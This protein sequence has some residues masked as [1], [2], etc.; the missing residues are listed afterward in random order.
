MQ[1][2]EIAAEIARLEVAIVKTR[3]EKLRTDYRKAAAA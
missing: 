2:N 3:S 1:G